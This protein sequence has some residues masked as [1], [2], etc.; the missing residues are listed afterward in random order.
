MNSFCCLQ[1]E[2]VQLRREEL[3]V[4]G[5][6]CGETYLTAPGAGSDI[7]NN[8]RGFIRVHKSQ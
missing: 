6:S 4:D 1:V 8:Y 5:V 3:Q 7:N 2:H